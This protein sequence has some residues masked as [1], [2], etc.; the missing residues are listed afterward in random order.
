[1]RER[2]MEQIDA[3]IDTTLEAAT[4]AAAATNVKSRSARETFTREME[5]LP[6]IREV[7]ADVAACCRRFPL[8]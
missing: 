7:R 5:G 2:E 8:P 1:M 4:P 6:V 3:W